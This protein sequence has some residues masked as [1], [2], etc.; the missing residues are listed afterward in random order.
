MPNLPL[1]NQKWAWNILVFPIK[2]HDER[3]GVVLSARLI[4]KR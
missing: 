3:K 1:R 4:E 2:L